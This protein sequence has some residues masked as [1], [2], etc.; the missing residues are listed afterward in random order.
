MGLD[1][2]TLRERPDLRPQVFAP[3][4]QSIWPEF[5]Q[6][7]AAAGLYFAPNYLDRYLD[8]AFAGVAD[9]KV[10]ARAFSVPFA[11]DIDGRAELPDGGWDRVIR[12]AHDD[13]NTGR[14]PN[15]MSALEISLL[16]QARGGGNSA[17]LIG[18][19]KARARTQGF[20]EVFAPVRPNQKHLQ[21]RMSMRD[22]V[23]TVRPD[24]FPID[25]WLRTHLRLGAKVVKIAP[26][27]MT[28]VGRPADWSRWTA[29]R[30]IDPARCWWRARSRRSWFRSSRIARCISSP[31]S[32]SGIRWSVV[33]SSA[34]RRRD[35]TPA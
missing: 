35:R 33:S 1:I 26:Y 25:S 16:P 29:C 5:M 23:D 14:V 15:T 28:I 3:E 13:Q 17:A 10:V 30:S 9:G 20:A 11:F 7:S 8:Y 6:H 18:A 24:G 31:M 22:Y 19:M 12:W 32:G 4:L 34:R 21:P 2:F 27:S